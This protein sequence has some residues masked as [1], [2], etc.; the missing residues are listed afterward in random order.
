MKQPTKA[1][2]RKQILRL[3]TE[4][5]AVHD[6]L[7]DSVDITQVRRCKKCKRY[8]CMPGYICFYCKQDPTLPIV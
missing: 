3:H 1:N 4:L 8:G 7:R 5:K 2:L 6:D